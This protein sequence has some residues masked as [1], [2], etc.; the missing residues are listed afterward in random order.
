MLKIYVKNCKKDV[1]DLQI[2]VSFPSFESINL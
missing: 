2:L 1:L